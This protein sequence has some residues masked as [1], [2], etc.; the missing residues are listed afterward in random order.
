MN[1][2]KFWRATDYN[3]VRQVTST[4]ASFSAVWTELAKKI[5]SDL[6]N[7]HLKIQFLVSENAKIT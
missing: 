6:L 5:H 7:T 2:R 1:V 4:D 3:Y